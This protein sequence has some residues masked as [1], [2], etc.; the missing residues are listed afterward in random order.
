M[1]D[2]SI[3][4]Q[5]LSEPCLAENHPKADHAVI[6]KQIESGELAPIDFNGR[7][8]VYGHN[9]NH[10]TFYEQDL[11]ALASSFKNRPF[12]RDHDAMNLSSRDGIIIDS[13]FNSLSIT[14]KIQVTT[15]QGMTDYVEGR[16][17]RFSISWE[18]EDIHCSICRS[19]W[20]ACS[21]VGGR[22]YK[23]SPN[24]QE[25]PC[26]LIFT[27]PIGKET[28]AVN[29]P[30]VD[31]TSILSMLTDLRDLLRADQPPAYHTSIAPHLPS[32]K[33]AGTM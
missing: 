30:A 6:L 27:K 12:L 2:R 7:V 13:T 31:G 19:S 11:P 20:F 8:F 29:T 18:Y 10:L 15:R 9:R 26:E 21:H 32:R 25:I 28:S 14:Q 24:S 4:P 17:D 16:I 33:S 22:T 3:L 1:K 5:L 23:A